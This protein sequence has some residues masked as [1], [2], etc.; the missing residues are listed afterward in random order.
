MWTDIEGLLVA[1]GSEISK[2]SGSRLRF[3]LNE[4]HIIGIQAFQ[5]VSQEDTFAVLPSF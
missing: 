4:A 3:K 5:N 2:G 1:L